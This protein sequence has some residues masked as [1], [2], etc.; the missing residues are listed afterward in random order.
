MKT[1]NMKNRQL[2]YATYARVGLPPQSQ[3]SLAYQ[4]KTLESLAQK[5]KLNLVAKFEEMGSTR[6][7][8]REVFAKLLNGIK[9]GKTNAVLVASLDRLTRD[10]KEGK[11]LIGLMDQGKL[12]EIRTRT[13]TFRNNKQDKFLLG[14]EMNMMKSDSEH[15]SFVIKRGLLAKKNQGL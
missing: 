9:S 8:N 7:V 2:K 10:G 1:D 6:Q 5:A 4:T 13:Y 3:N 11:R 14:L 15:R 12:K